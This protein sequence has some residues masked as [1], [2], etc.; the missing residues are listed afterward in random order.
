MAVKLTLDI[1]NIETENIVH[2]LMIEDILSSSDYDVG[3]KISSVG[4]Y[5]CLTGHLINMN[6]GKLIYERLVKER[7]ITDITNGT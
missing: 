3:V 7:I 5:G 1:D 2:T 6:T 4:D